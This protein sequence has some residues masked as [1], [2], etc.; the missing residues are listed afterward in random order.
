MTMRAASM[1]RE[2]PRA[3]TSVIVAFIRTP[4]EAAA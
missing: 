1:I 4:Y 2:N 3:G